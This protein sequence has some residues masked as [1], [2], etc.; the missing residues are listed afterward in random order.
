[1]EAIGRALRGVQWL[2]GRLSLLMGALACV[3]IVLITVATLAE[4]FRRYLLGTSFLGV[5]EFVELLVAFVFFAL[6][7]YTQ[8]RKAHLRLTLFID[9]LPA[10]IVLPLETIV[11]LLILGFI[12]LMVWQAWVEAIISTERR[13]I[14]FG[15]V[16]YPLWPAKL[17]AAAAVSVMGL[18]LLADFLDRLIATIK[19]ERPE[20]PL[21]RPTSEADQV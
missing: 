3:C 20:T 17:A 9:R 4:V 8:Y 15:A 18:Q 19:G 21:G 13:Q 14:R 11:L 16:P 1:M 10:R 6:L 5:I 12:G 2:I 7:S